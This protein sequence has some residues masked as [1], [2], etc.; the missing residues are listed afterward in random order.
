KTAA[1]L[2]ERL[3][4]GLEPVNPLD[5]WG[6]GRDYI[7]VFADCLTALVQDPD[8]AIAGLFAETGWSRY[9]IAGYQ[10]ALLKTLASTQKPVLLPPNLSPVDPRD[11]AKIL[12]EH[13]IPSIGGTLPALRAVKGAMAY[14]DFLERPARPTPL[15][16][17]MGARERWVERLQNPEVLDEAES[18]AL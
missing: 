1:R 9:F 10:D 15:A 4:Y 5:A 8:T 18:L 14:R 16:P 2:E 12:I 11:I 3:E 17:P 7:N 6:T 13:G